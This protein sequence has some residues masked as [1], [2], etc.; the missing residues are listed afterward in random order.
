[1]N[2]FGRYARFYDAIYR[3]KNYPLEAN[4]IDA[5]IK[6]YHKD[7]ERVLDLGCGTGE[8]AIALARKGYKV[9]GVDNSAEMLDAASR[10]I[11]A[12][13]GDRLKVD[14]VNADIRL[15]KLGANFDAVIS[16]FHVISYLMSDDE[17]KAAF[18]A[19]GDH[20]G[21][22]GIFI[23][24]CWY[25]PAVLN[26]KPEKRI[27]TTE[28]EELSII[29]YAEPEFVSGGKVVR[30]NYRLV[31]KN[32]STGAVETFEERHELR[33]F[34]S[35]EIDYMLKDAGFSMLERAEWLTGKAAGPDTWGVCFV[36]GK[37]SQ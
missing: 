36:A 25:G 8:H 9:T 35:D 14:F 30:V 19:A 15:L 37:S 21:R 13:G 27:K 34:Y 11:A 7:A 10:K 23:F 16:L 17:V 26:S 31:V 4:Y 5:L 20:L 2:I 18:K 33:Y 24:D 6:K 1:M 32:K 12:P 29:R 22:G 3:D 28:T